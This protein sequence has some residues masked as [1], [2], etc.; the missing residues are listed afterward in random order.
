MTTFSGIFVGC[1]SIAFFCSVSSG[2]A[3]NLVANFVSTFS[4]DFVCTFVGTLTGNFSVTLF[5]TGIFVC[6]FSACFT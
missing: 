3:G 6:T 1:L 4:G 5:L 2:F